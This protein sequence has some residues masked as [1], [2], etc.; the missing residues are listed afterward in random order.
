MC[1][2]GQGH[3]PPGAWEQDF[4]P[5]GIGVRAWKF[6]GCGHKFAQLAQK[7]GEPSGV[8]GAMLPGRILKNRVSLMPFPTFWCGFL[9]M[10]QVTNEKKY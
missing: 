3:I 10:E 5:S 8:F 2:K 1:I 9:C 4:P 6:W 7:A